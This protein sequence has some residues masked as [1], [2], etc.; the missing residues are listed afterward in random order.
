MNSALDYLLVYTVIVSTLA[1][2]ISLW[3]LFNTPR[4]HD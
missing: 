2:V 3:L 4:I 1:L